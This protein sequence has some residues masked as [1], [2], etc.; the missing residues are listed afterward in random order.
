MPT[1]VKPKSP[2]VGVRASS[3]LQVMSNPSSQVRGQKL[4]THRGV[5]PWEEGSSGTG[6]DESGRGS[7][8]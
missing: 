4:A 7:V 6:N 8:S 2:S 3:A 1:G 5:A